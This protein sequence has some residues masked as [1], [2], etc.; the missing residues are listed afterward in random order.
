VIDP[1][2][3]VIFDCDG[4]LVDSEP[5]AL[6]ILQERLAALGLHKPDREVVDRFVGRS[7][8]A[9]RATV[10]E[11]LGG[12]VPAGW[13]EGFAAAVR[14]AHETQLRPVDGVVDAL[15]GLDELGVAMCVA[16][17][18]THAKIGHSLALVGLADRFAGRVFSAT[19]VAHGKPAPDL[20]L[21][22]AAVC[23]V[24]PAGCLVVEDS[25]YGVRAARAAGMRCVAYGGG[26]T[27]PQWLAGPGTVVV[28]DLRKLPGYV[29]ATLP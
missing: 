4:V 3:L 28:T 26:I 20:F 16:S 12:P 14:D 2:R 23:G 6:R 5:I 25:R 15:A 17:S 21:H 13:L 19:D 1:V 9:T 24:A 11:Y 7:L 27:P 22:A 10:E 8:S 18:G 29:A